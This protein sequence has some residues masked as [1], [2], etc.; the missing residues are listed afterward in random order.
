MFLLKK[1]VKGFI[2]ILCMMIIFYFSQDTGIQSTKKSDGVILEVSSF[3]GVHDLS[4]KEQQFL[5]DTFVVPVRKSAHF[6]IYLVLGI[7]LI[8]FLREF[9]LSPHKLV[10]I[11]I[12]L[13]FLY[14]CSDEVHQLFVIGRSGQFSDVVLDTIGASVGVLFYYILFRKKLKE[15]K[16]E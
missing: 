9:L 15:E 3:L 5:I 6:L 2:V 12:F 11:S 8:S 10:L 14:A 13:A 4:M 1:I 7:T 16:Y